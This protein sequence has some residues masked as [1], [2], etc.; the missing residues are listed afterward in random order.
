MVDMQR[1]EWLQ[2]LLNE[3]PE[4]LFV[5]NQHGQFVE[6]FGG[7]FHSIQFD[8]ADCLHD[9]VSKTKADELLHI[10]NSVLQTQT[11]QVVQ[12]SISPLDCLQLSIGELEQL[13]EEAWFEAKIKP[14]GSVTG[15]QYVL[16]QER[17]ITDAYQR[18]QHLKRLSETDELTN[19]LNRR[20]FMLELNQ[21]F[22]AAR[23]SEISASCLMVD[24]DHFKEINDQVGHLSGDE[25]ITHVAHICQQHIR[26]NDAIGRLGG[27]EFGILLNNISA[28]QAYDIAERIRES[29]ETTPCHVDGKT[30]YPTASIGISEID[31]DMTDVKELLI[32]ADKAMYY[33]KHTGRNQVTVH[34]HRLPDMKIATNTNI[35]ILIAS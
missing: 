16:W 9:L 10:I 4:Q 22:T 20:A 3:L 30:I 25:V 13:Q 34:H 23:E 32:Q 2:L 11:P 17:N 8:S 19:V 29:I 26:A 7:T 5:L 31:K 33:S 35:K 14:L 15:K 27:E 28:I 1:E 6:G 21:A 24:I 18:E 12:Y